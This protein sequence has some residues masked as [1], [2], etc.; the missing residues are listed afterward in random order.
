M[1]LVQHINEHAIFASKENRFTFF[2]MQLQNK[3]VQYSLSN[4]FLRKSSSFSMNII[5]NAYSSM[6][7]SSNEEHDASF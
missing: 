6:S 7:F 5:R 4:D 3:K 1:E 2:Q